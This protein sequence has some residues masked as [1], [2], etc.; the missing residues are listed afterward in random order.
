MCRRTI[1][2]VWNVFTAGLV[3]TDIFRVGK[4]WLSGCTCIRTSTLPESQC[5]VQLI[6]SLVGVLMLAKIV[7]PIW[8][9]RGFLL[10]TATVNFWTGF[11]TFVL[12]YLLYTIDRKGDV[13]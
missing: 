13:L 6:L 1:P 7:E 12:I 10:F 9:S 11:S 4:C 5:L 8:G 2:C 3:E